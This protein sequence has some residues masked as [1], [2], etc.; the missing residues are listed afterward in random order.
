MRR[1]APGATGSEPPALL[2]VRAWLDALVVVLAGAVTMLVVACLGLWAA[3]A[4]HLPGEAYPRVVVAM[5]VMAVGGEVQLSGDAGFLAQTDA[6][7]EVVPLSVTLAGALVMAV[8]FLLP[9]RHRAVATGREVLDRVVRTAVLWCL[10][11]VLLALLARHTF[12]VSVG[13]GLAEDIGDLLDANPTVGFRADVPA[14]LG[15]GLLWLLAVLALTFLV[16]HRAPL[17]SRLLHFQ[18]SV[19]P[20]AFAMVAVLLLYVA[21]GV[22]VG[23]VVAATRGHPAETLAALLLGLPNLVWLAFG[24]GIGGSW[25]GRVAEGIGLPVP[26]VLDEVLRTSG[27]GNATLDL[28]AVAERDDR[29]WVLVVVAVIALLAAGFLTAVRSPARIRPWQHAW[30]L[31][32]AMALTMLVIGL[33]TRIFAHYGLTVIGVGDLGGGLGGEVSLRANFLPLIGFGALW[34][35]AAGF[36]GGLLALRVRHHGAVEARGEEARGQGAG[37]PSGR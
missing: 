15:F 19:R 33:L 9:L 3:G 1:P 10:M 8:L 5:V 26:R 17:P 4:P 24:V 20:P 36:L 28:A 2:P 6:A 16:S 31:G 14:T 18:E 13:G 30:H 21:I 12:E 22:V 7:V 27:G 29:A 32:L 23:L 25:D 37:G 34:G 35:L 11:L